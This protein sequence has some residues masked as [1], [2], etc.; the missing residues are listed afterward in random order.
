MKERSTGSKSSARRQVTELPPHPE[1]SLFEETEYASMP[2]ILLASLDT[3]AELGY[4]GTAT[5][6]IS[7]AP[8][9]APA[10]STPTTTPS[11]PCSS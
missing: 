1:E 10:P 9:S 7:V 4:H 5:R 8:R 3:F 11:R 6:D 2:R